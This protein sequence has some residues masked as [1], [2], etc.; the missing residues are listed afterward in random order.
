VLSELRELMQQA[1]AHGQNKVADIGG[2]V[3][4]QSG[5]APDGRKLRI[6]WFVGYQGDIAFAVVELSRSAAGSAAP[7]AGRFLRNLQTGS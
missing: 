7:L 6:S 3:Y 2:D 4:A 1:A 5:N